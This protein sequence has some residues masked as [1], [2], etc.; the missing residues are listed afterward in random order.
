MRLLEH[1]PEKQ[2]YALSIRNDGHMQARN[3]RSSYFYDTIPKLWVVD[4][5]LEE[6][7]NI[8]ACFPKEKEGTSGRGE[9]GFRVLSS[10]V[11]HRNPY[12]FGW[13]TCVELSQCRG[14]P[15]RSLKIL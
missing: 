12:L 15:A 9:E 5:P 13:S 11:C 4:D 3:W 8:Y 6:R 10:F 1:I 2:L 7:R 14:E